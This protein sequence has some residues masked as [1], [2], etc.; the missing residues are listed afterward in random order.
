MPIDK[1]N[2]L[3]REDVENRLTFGGFL[4]FHCPLKP[5]A[6]ETLKM[7]A[8]SSHRIKQ[9][10][11]ITGDNPPTAVHVTRNVEIVD[12]DALILDLR[13]NPTHEAGLVWRIVDETK[14]ILVDPSQPLDLKRLFD[15]YDICVTGATTKHE[16]V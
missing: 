14:I 7:L 8:E 1:I 10:I 2:K 16:T 13:E 5:D 3:S 12:R 15:E 4:V 6:V 11:M 9:C